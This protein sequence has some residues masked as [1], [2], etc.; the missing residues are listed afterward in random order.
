MPPPRNE[1]ADDERLRRALD[2]VERLTHLYT[3]PMRVRLDL[4]EKELGKVEERVDK[5][6]DSHF[7]WLAVY[8]SLIVLVISTLVG[9]IIK[10]V[11]K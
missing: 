7:R 5:R 1:S 8:T 4:L 11:L 10:V 9:I 6:I 3:E 2:N